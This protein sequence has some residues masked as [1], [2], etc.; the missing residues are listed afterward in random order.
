MS[1]ENYD[2]LLA[3]MRNQPLFNKFFGADGL[4]YCNITDHDALI[5]DKGWIFEGG[6]YI[7]PSLVELVSIQV[8][9]DT[10]ECF[11]SSVDLG[12]PIAEGCG[13]IEITNNAPAEF[14]IGITEVIWI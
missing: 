6:T 13:V 5:N 2:L 4:T 10:G 12:A 1:S 9:P 14:P 11:A 8:T 7:T 3:S